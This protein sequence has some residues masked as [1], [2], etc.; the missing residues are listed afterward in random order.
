M[1]PDTAHQ[2]AALVAAH[3]DDLPLD[4]GVATLAAGEDL[5]TSVD[6]AC[7]TF[8]HLAAGLYLPPGEP[9]PRQL[10]RLTHHLFVHHD[11]AGDTACYDDPR[12]SFVHLVPARRRGLPILL[13]AI[14]I[15]VGRRAG[16]SLHGVGFPGHFLVAPTDATPPFWLD[17]FER[18]AVRT[19]E[20][21]VV[22]LADIGVPP[23]AWA[24]WLSPT[25]ARQILI[26]MAHNLAAS[27][28][29]RGMDADVARQHA[30]IAAL[31]GG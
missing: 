29:R 25:P 30:T 14:T 1:R 9:L 15:E 28:G 17:P 4:V 2:L 11:L 3:G 31:G 27:Y 16:L 7:A 12:N 20:A 8:D 5:S 23:S 26:R 10:A 22:R 13:S 19:R 24:S 21:L 18:G 6:E